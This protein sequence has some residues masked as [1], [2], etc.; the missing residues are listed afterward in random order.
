MLRAQNSQ[1]FLAKFLLLQ[2]LGVC[3]GIYQRAVVDEL[4]MIRTQLRASSR[5]ENGRSAWDALYGTTVK[6]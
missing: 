3:A 2:L 1:P 4:G 5:S 6:Q